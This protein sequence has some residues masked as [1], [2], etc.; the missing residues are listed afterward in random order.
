VLRLTE[1]RL[2]LDH[3]ADALK[4]AVA[5]RLRVPPSDIAD[6]HVF[7]RGHDARK[8]AAILLVYT[9]DIAI[10]NEAAVLKRHRKDRNIGPTPD[11]RYRHVARAPENVRRPVV[12]GMGP[13]GL[14]AGLV[15]AEMGF[16]PIILDRGKVIQTGTMNE[17]TAQSEEFRVTIATGELPLAAIQ[18]L[19]GVQSAAVENQRTL[20]V[21]FDVKAASAEQMVTRVLK[22]LIDQGLLISNL[23]RG[24]KL[25]DRVMQLT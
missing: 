10:K 25:E 20:V 18:A 8:K 3:P 21:R 19:A 1:L 24:R 4:A 11:T 5:K 17:L 14:F 12:I 16:R 23:T 22:A 15:L 9:V 6:V 7:R 13:C 2:P